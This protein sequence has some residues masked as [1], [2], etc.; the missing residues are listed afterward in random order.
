MK[1]TSITCIAILFFSVGCTKKTKTEATNEILN[2]STT[3]IV[4]DEHNAKNSLDYIGMYKGIVP[5]ADCEGIETIL[6]LR[7]E[8]NF[9]LTTH[10]LGKKDSKINELK[11]TYT[12]NK[13]GNTVVLSGIENGPSQ[14]FVSENYLTQLD[15]EGNKIT[16]DLASKYVL[17]KQNETAVEIAPPSPP[18]K[19]NFNQS[20][21]S[22]SVQKQVG[23]EVYAVV[24]TKW[25][26]VELNGRAIKNINQSTKDLFLQLNKENRYSAFAGC[27]SMMGQ[28]ELKEEIF[29]IKFSKGASTMMACP[30]METEQEFA[31]MLET[32]DNYSLNGNQ[33]TL[34]KARMAPLARFEAIKK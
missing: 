14:Y 25:R 16:G 31:K 5:C 7:D 12:W 23:K 30:D 4:I 3:I 11:G 28:Y 1:I 26:L 21:T 15:L 27:N 29:R 32:V 2:D 9:V 19:S 13:E 33:M 17:E 6:N 20:P 8:S 34:N 18:T 24:G 10:Y 22:T